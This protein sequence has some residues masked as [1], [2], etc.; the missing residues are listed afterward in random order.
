MLL[1]AIVSIYI[2]VTGNKLLAGQVDRGSMA[3]IL[4]TPIKRRTISLTQ[5]LYFT[6]SLALTFLTTT[7]T[8][9]AVNYLTDANFAVPTILAL[10]FGAFAVSFALAGI[11]YAASGIFNLSKHVMGTG[12]VLVLAFLILAIVGSFADFGVPDLDPVKN[13]TI[14]SLFDIKD[15][16]IEGTK[17]L[18]QLGILGVIGLVGFGTGSIAFSKKDLPL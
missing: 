18:P 13:L 10:N 16:L 11:M 15:I 1:P 8:F 4:S 12:G 2:I 5:A 6:G 7:G 17:W 14:L 3:Y 9:L